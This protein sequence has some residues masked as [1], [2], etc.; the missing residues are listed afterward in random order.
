MKN[1]DWGY[2]IQE[3]FKGYNVGV[4]YALAKNI[5]YNLDYFDI[6]GKESEKDSRVIWSRLQINF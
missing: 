6:E 4:N 5:V 3:G 2:F 1:G